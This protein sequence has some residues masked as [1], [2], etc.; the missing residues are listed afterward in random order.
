MS[1]IIGLLGIALIVAGFGYE[2]IRTISVK[3]CDMNRYV[4][5]L[6]IAAS[7]LLL[8]YAYSLGDHIFMALNAILVGINIVNFYYA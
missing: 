2:M 1:E 8:F 5:S 3:R 6:F 7:L 4:I